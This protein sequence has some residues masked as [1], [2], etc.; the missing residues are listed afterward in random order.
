MKRTLGFVLTMIICAAS[1]AYADPQADAVMRSSYALP[2]ATTMKSTMYMLLV[3]KNGS[4][5]LRAISMY[6]RKTADGTDSYIDFLSPPDVKGT[7]FLTIA[8]AGGDDQRLWLPDLRKIRRIAT[9]GK[10]AKFMGSDLTY[11]DMSAHHFADSRYAMHGDESISV[12]RN[13]TKENVPCWV[14][15]CTPVDPGVPY[16]R[17]RV[18]VGKDDHFVY[19]STM[20]NSRGEEEKTVY[21]LEVRKIDGIIIP[22]K[23]AVSAS[24]GHKTL[25]QMNDVVLNEP[26]DPGLFTVAQLER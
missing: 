22:I 20:W 10:G 23:T 11:Y 7:K 18:W 13:G 25:L 4:Q 8:T 19:R 9:S 17:T 16:A 26:L 1:V 3:E 12:T 6:S 21:I 14:I 24:D 15:D 2:G 5:S